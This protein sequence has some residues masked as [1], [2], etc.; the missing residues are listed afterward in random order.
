MK[1]CTHKR[2]ANQV[3]IYKQM[4]TAA[5]SAH[6]GW[7][8]TL[9]WFCYQSL[10]PMVVGHTVTYVDHSPHLADVR[11]SAG[12]RLPAGVPPTALRLV[13][14]SPPG[15]RRGYGLGERAGAVKIVVC[16]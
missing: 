2:S 5:K 1:R 7:I 3:K 16:P 6:A 14:R 13:T 11:D 10:C 9:G 4:E 12:D 8:D 15:V